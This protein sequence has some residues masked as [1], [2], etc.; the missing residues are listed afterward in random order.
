M[1]SRRPIVAAD[2]FVSG[3][4][5]YPWYRI[6]ALVRLPSGAIAAFAEGRKT[7]TDIGYN[8]VVYK[9]SHDEGA[10]WSRLRV[11][12]SESNATHHVAIHN[13]VPVVTGGRPVHPFAYRSVRRALLASQARPGSLYGCSR[14]T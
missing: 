5:G 9:V 3:T 4:E 8:D 10:T 2:V 12:W 1:C 6:P 14:S 13:P 7:P 11:L